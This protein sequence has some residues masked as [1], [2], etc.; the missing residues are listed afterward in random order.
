MVWILGLVT[1][2]LFIAFVIIIP[3][4]GCRYGYGASL[5]HSIIA[6]VIFW[7]FLGLVYVIDI[8]Y[9]KGRDLAQKRNKGQQN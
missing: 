6:A 4:L 2:M 9:T 7:V 3:Y 1:G 8:A 5:K